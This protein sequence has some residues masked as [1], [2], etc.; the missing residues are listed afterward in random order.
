MPVEANRGT[1]RGVAGRLF[2]PEGRSVLLERAS[3]LHPLRWAA[4]LRD[5]FHAAFNKHLPEPS[6][7][8]LA[9]VLLGPPAGPGA[10]RRRFPTE[11]HVPPAGRLRVERGVFPRGVVGVFPMGVVVATTVDHRRGAFRC[12]PL[13]V[14]GGGSPPVIR[15]AVM[16]TVG[17]VGALLGRWDRMEHP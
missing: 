6:A 17:S 4:A 13:R 12:V 14:D 8:L 9:G 15:A 7:Q 11:W 10:V 16:A 1:P 2:V 3:P 5:R